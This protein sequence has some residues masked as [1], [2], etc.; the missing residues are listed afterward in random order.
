ML[1][2]AYLIVR[3]APF[4][5]PPAAAPQDKLARLEGRTMF[6]R[7]VDSAGQRVGLRVRAVGEAG[8]A[9]RRRVDDRRGSDHHVGDQPAGARPD[10]EAMAGKAGGDKEPGE[11]VDCRDDRDRIG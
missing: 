5:T 8:E 2:K 4:E 10:A 1:S 9:E 7:S 3:S 6:V 11:A